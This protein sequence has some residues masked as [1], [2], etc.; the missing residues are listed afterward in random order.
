MKDRKV[1]RGMVSLM[2]KKSL[3]SSRMRNIFVMVTIALASALLMAI[4]MFS[5]GQRQQTTN[6]LSHRQQVSYYNLTEGQVERLKEDQRIACQ[7]QVKEG[8][9]SGMEGFDVMPYYVSSLSGE[10]KIA[11]LENGNMPT[12]EQEVALQAALLEKMGIEPAVGSEVAFHFYDGNT[13]TFTVSGILEGGE[14]TKQF[15]VFFSEKY[16]RAGSQLKG[17]PFTVYA[18]LTG[19]EGLPAGECKEIMYKIGQDAG[20]ERK[21]ISP[22]KAFLDSRSVNMQSASLYGVVGAFILL[23]SI[24]VVYGVFYLS[25]IGK[26]HQYGQLR[27]IGMTKKQMK[28][29][30]S[31]EGALLFLRS[32]PLGILVGGAAGYFMVPDGFSAANAV[33]AAALVFAAV[34]GITMVSIHRPARTAASVSPMEAL[35]YLPQGG[36][37]QAANKKVCRSLT[38]LGLGRMNFSKNRK[39]AGLTML[40]L[41]FGGILFMAAATYM[42]SFDREQYVRQGQFTDAEFDINY[43]NSAIELDEY[44]LS[45]LQAK[46]PL[47]GMVEEIS[48]WDGVKQVTGMKNLGVVFDFPKHGEY[49]VNDLVGLIS[50]E[51][52]RKIGTYLEEGSA[53]YGSLMGGG[54]VLVAGN[55]VA[56]EIYGWKFEVGDKIVFRYYDGSKMAEQEVTVLG[57][58]NGQYTLDFNEAGAWFLMPEQSVLGMV[59]YQ[60]LNSSLQVST[61]PEQE[62]AIGEKLAELVAGRPELTMETLAERRVAY[63]QNVDQIFGAISGLAIFIMMFSILSMMNT[64]ITNIVTRKQELA[65]LESIG[66]GKGQIRQMLLGESLFLS[67][68]ALGITMAAGTLCGYALCQ[69]LYSNGAFYMAFRFPAAFALAYAALLLIVPFSIT[70]ASLHNFSKETLVERLRGVEN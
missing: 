56:E 51:E 4:L 44:G 61:E 11:A 50:E 54:S 24:L 2:A 49:G 53:D 15:P 6:A 35:R 65:M 37:E 39:K 17:Q 7:V 26:I 8:I 70:F 23:A 20:V 38:P 55:S 57:I 21:N 13:E 22:S 40:S 69:A 45:G 46:K 48:A 67:S 33:G 66:M 29:F 14:N 28:K 47:A 5:M 25:V 12:R 64:M 18:K 59:S 16:A 34:Y 10:I 27:T 63:K 68:V 41:G 30:V 60:S 36:M 32:A 52:T 43:A 3:K 62:D 19:A 1:T 9:L 58:L 42:S 31:R